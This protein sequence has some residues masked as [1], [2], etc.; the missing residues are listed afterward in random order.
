MVKL[1][2]PVPVG[3]YVADLPAGEPAFAV[4]VFENKGQRCLGTVLPRVE[5]R[6]TVTY[7]LKGPAQSESAS[8]NGLSFEMTHA[9]SRS[10]SI[11]NY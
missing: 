8:A 1:K 10:S 4:Q 6:R 7:D 2:Q 3:L 9:T 5:A 11:N